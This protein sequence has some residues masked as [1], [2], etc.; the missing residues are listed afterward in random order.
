MSPLL[1]LQGVERPVRDVETTVIFFLPKLVGDFCEWDPVKAPH[2]VR[3]EYGVWELT[4]EPGT[5]SH[6]CAVKARITAPDFTWRDVVPVWIHYA[7]MQKRSLFYKVQVHALNVEHKPREMD[8]FFERR[9]RHAG[10][11]SD[12]TRVVILKVHWMNTHHYH[13]CYPWQQRRV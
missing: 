7:G 9:V 1:R 8:L 12:L 6:G 13:S 11:T 3:G 5:I 4:L 2:C 10:T